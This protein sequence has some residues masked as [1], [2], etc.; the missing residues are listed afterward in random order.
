M[1][2]GWRP[3]SKIIGPI[4]FNFDNFVVDELVDELTSFGNNYK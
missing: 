2:T 3:K 1:V 4:P